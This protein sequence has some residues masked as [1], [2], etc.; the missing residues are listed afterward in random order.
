MMYSP[1]VARKEETR[2]R[3]IET[4]S[5][6]FMEKGVDGVG[7]DEIMRES[8]L[9]H[10]GFYVHFE[11]KDALIAEAALYAVDQTMSKWQGLPKKLADK[12]LFDDFLQEF[13]DGNISTSSPACPM[14][15]LGP[16]ISRR[17]EKVQTAYVVKMRELIDYITQEMGSDRA[18]AILCLSA[19]VGATSLAAQTNTDKALAAEILEATREE[20]L[21]CRPATD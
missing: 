18:H 12:N 21:K 19:M 13:V 10:G 15:L 6:L 3:I 2:R 5:R 1:A 7:V 20:L 16:D 17:S 11:N 9:T 8:G 4:A 14:A